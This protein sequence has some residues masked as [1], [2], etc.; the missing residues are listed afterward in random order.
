M[1]SQKPGRRGR[2]C[3]FVLKKR[4]DT[5]KSFQTMDS[6]ARLLKVCITTVLNTI[7]K[8]K[9][10]KGFTIECINKKPN[11]IRMFTVNGK[12]INKFETI[13][14]AAKELNKIRKGN[15]SSLESGIS[16]SIRTETLRFGYW[17]RKDGFKKPSIVAS[18]QSNI[19]KKICTY[20]RY[21]ED[22]DVYKKCGKIFIS[23][24]SYNHYCPSCREYIDYN[25]I[26]SYEDKEVKISNFYNNEK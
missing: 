12:L 21:Y 19:H 26:S 14:D 13:S 20:T 9:N 11:Y 22:K 3:E 4:G 5:V 2:N 6:I 23:E 7:N 8:K 25:A 10:L 18:H 1:T 17:W 15:L 24:G 16:F